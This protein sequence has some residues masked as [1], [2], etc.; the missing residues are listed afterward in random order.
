MSSSSSASGITTRRRRKRLPAAVTAS[1]VSAFD[2][3]NVS[4]KGAKNKR[5]VDTMP[6]ELDLEKCTID[7]HCAFGRAARSCAAASFW[8]KQSSSYMDAILECSRTLSKRA[9]PLQL[10]E[11]EEA[12][13]NA[14]RQSVKA[15]TEQKVFGET[16]V[17]EL[18]VATHALRALTTILFGSPLTPIKLVYHAIVTLSDRLQN[19]EN[20]AIS[21]SN[22]GTRSMALSIGVALYEILGNFLKDSSLCTFEASAALFEFPVPTSN[23]TRAD[24]QQPLKIGIQSTLAVCNVLLRHKKP[25]ST[26]EF[27]P[28]VASV[29]LLKTTV[30]IV[31]Q[32][33]LLVIV[34]WTRTYAATPKSHKELISFTKAAHRLLWDVAASQT[35]HDTALELRRDAILALILCDDDTL[36]SD[37]RML[38]STACSELAS[39]YAW[40]AAASYVQQTKLLI[41]VEGTQNPLYRFHDVIGKALARIARPRCMSYLEYCS[42]RSLHMGIQREKSSCSCRFF[43]KYPYKFGHVCSDG[44]AS[45]SLPNLGEVTLGLIFVV[46]SLERELGSETLGAVSLESYGHYDSLHH[47]EQ[48]HHSALADFQSVVAA[49]QTPENLRRCYKLLQQTMLPHRCSRQRKALEDADAAQL[50]SIQVSAWKVCGT[51]LSTAV[52]TVL[53]LLI[54][55]ELDATRRLDYW[56]DMIDVYSRVISLYDAL[57]S[58]TSDLSL[59]P[60]INKLILEIHMTV[61]LT[62]PSIGSVERLA[63]LLFS[64]GK[65]RHDSNIPGTIPLVYSL[66]FL[67]RLE[68]SSCDPEFARSRQLMSRY[69]YLASCLV[70]LGMNDAALLA[71]VC[72]LAYDSTTEAVESPDSL[73]ATSSFL[74]DLSAGTPVTRNTTAS[75]IHRL[76]PLL[77]RDMPIEA[78]DAAPT[79]VAISEGIK[80]ASIGEG[81]GFTP[82]LEKLLASAFVDILRRCHPRCCDSVRG[83]QARTAGILLVSLGDTIKR[84]PS[85]ERSTTMLHYVFKSSLRLLYRLLKRMQSTTDN[86][87]YMLGLSHFVAASSLTPNQNDPKDEVR[88]LYWNQLSRAAK[89]LEEVR[90][91]DQGNQTASLLWL[92][93]VH[94][95]ICLVGAY[96]NTTLIEACKQVVRKL[97]GFEVRAD[98]KL[99]SKVWGCVQALLSK[100]RSQFTLSGDFVKANKV[101]YWNALLS[102]KMGVD[103]F[104]N[105]WFTAGAIASL[106]RADFDSLAHVLSG[107]MD[108]RQQSTSEWGALCRF[109]AQ[110]SALRLQG[111]TKVP[112]RLHVCI[113]ELRSI[114]DIMGM[115]DRGADALQVI[116]RWV[117]GS[118]LLALAEIYI[119]LHQGR[120]AVEAL[121][122]CMKICQTGAKLSKRGPF[123]DNTLPLSLS[124]MD[125]LFM[126]RQLECLL[127]LAQAYDV[128]GDYR[129]AEAYLL[130]ASEQASLQGLGTS[131]VDLRSLGESS[132]SISSVQQAVCF[133]SLVSLKAQ[134]HPWEELKTDL[135]SRVAWSG[136]PVEFAVVDDLEVQLERLRTLTPIL[137][138][139][140]LPSEGVDNL[141]LS[142]AALDM[143]VSHDFVSSFEVLDELSMDTNVFG[144]AIARVKL[145]QAR[146]LLSLDG[147]SVDSMDAV[148]T[149]CY[150]LIGM[151]AVSTRLQSLAYYFLG[152]VH[153]GAAREKEV[154]RRLWEEDNELIDE[155][156]KDARAA[157]E[158][159]L[160][161]VDAHSL[162]LK[163]ELCRSLALVLGPRAKATELGLA[164]DALIHASIG[165][166]S[167][168]K[169]LSTTLGGRQ[170]EDTRVQQL[171]ESEWFD[172]FAL[173]KDCLPTAWNVVAIALCPTGELLIAGQHDGKRQC[174]CVFPEV[175]PRNLF[176]SSIYDQ[177]MMPIDV[178]IQQS[179]NQL[180]GMDESTAND[181][182]GEESA[183]RCWWSKRKEFDSRLRQLVDRTDKI[184]FHGESVRQVFGVPLQTIERSDS[185]DSPLRGN[186]ASMF[187]AVFESPPQSR[188]GEILHNLTVAQLK[189]RLQ[190][191]GVQFSSKH[192]KADL[193]QLLV[194]QGQENLRDLASN[195]FELTANDIECTILVLDENLHRFPFEGLSF[196]QGKAVTRVPSFAF[197][198]AS[199]LTSVP[200]EVDASNAR[201]VIDPECNLGKTAERMMPLIEFANRQN[202]WNWS[203]VIGEFPTEDFVLDSITQERGLFLFCGHG[204]GKGSFS[205]SRVESLMEGSESRMPCRSSI[206]L[207]GCSSGKLA[208]I[209]RKSADASKRVDIYYEPEGIALSYL[210]SG[211]PCVVGNLWDVTDRDIDRYCLEFMD[212]FLSHEGDSLAKC[213][214]EARSCCKM[215]HIVGLAPVCYGLPVVR[216]SF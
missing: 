128:F 43:G 91:R 202:G 161:L 90:A 95:Q 162:P 24:V 114:H 210:M 200:T 204:G 192:R 124:S 82:D 165:I 159:G 74:L 32:I 29:M 212:K 68:S 146:S 113:S 132:G 75:L 203:G 106:K 72:A 110:I 195:E 28:G 148:K 8:K 107:T 133:R 216:K 13:L 25:F 22:D 57:D 177:V 108:L 154:I 27:G 52:V 134:F 70:S 59:P 64:I 164:A 112:G 188:G 65:R 33:V 209:N 190:S 153:V 157:F 121:R 179:D 196:L 66:H 79:L 37:V 126:D 185:G 36:G 173:A 9:A 187:D 30:D 150:E 78:T 84:Q 214:A 42:Y 92:D 5:T 58:I 21:K 172:L 83:Q 56:D 26:S 86:A 139:S 60:M 62:K 3:E 19:A 76:I 15:A 89:A 145:C 2:K 4:N 99:Q 149:I 69:S 53:R 6:P 77:H 123:D 50:S 198:L 208:S 55:T 98:D 180:N 18:T 131:R 156:L 88:S 17:Q 67:T 51:I 182:F 194:E 170:C 144:N 166:T 105:C 34:R 122:N 80:N 93:M 14:C 138:P 44:G 176:D 35:N 23:T 85:E 140:F 116:R 151:S 152:L 141:L 39:S 193:I 189:E 163:R 118:R 102:R 167:K 205:R 147:C 169:F 81:I 171:V 45:N 186:L 197:L 183:K 73:D 104:S 16:L 109:E 96:N 103:D 71:I 125:N 63:R 184:Y 11:S 181:E 10:I 130:A 61:D 178:L 38:I 119:R 20:T 207:M 120:D 213:V 191:K 117:E 115:E 175:S 87:T 7:D 54:A 155:C 127:N 160:L 135:W 41:P 143:T 136:A 206:I 111:A 215:Q 174:T 97:L 199:L 211:A 142:I 47:L 49:Q 94:R 137:T 201:Y 40:K 100:V 168:A 48:V 101:A 158:S 1:E 46:A 129:K 31:K 12:L